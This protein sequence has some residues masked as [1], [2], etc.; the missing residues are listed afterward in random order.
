MHMADWPSPKGDFQMSDAQAAPAK[1]VEQRLLLTNAPGNAGPSK[2]ETEVVIDRYMLAAMGVGLVPVPVL[3]LV[4][5][6]AVQFKMIQKLAEMHGVEASDKRVRQVLISLLGGAVPAFGALPLF[7][8]AQMIPVIGWTVGAGAASILGGAS[9]YAVGHI[10][11]RHFE[12]G[13][14]MDD[15]KAE[16]TKKAFKELVEKGK[17]AAKSIRSRGKTIAEP[18]AAPAEKA[19]S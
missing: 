7:T 13:G 17:S 10:M 18:E 1:T 2:S 11:R 4:G 19:A 15:F 8:F 3:D 5:V 16:N 9:T 12:A 14:S 6:G